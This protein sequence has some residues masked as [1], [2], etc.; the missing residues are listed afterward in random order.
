VTLVRGAGFGL[1]T[2]MGSALIAGYAVPGARGSSLGAYGVA[3]S[4]WATFAPALGLAAFRGWPPL[5]A[6]AMGGLPPLLGLIAL[7]PRMPPAPDYATHPG[8]REGTAVSAT[9]VPPVTVFVAVAATLAAAFTFVPLLRVGSTTLLL[10]LFGTSFT[11][12]RLLAGYLL[13]RGRSATR[14]VLWLLVGVVIG[15]ALLGTLDT[16]VVAV[17]AAASGLGIGCV[18]TATL[19]M[20]LDRV[21][22]SG[23]AR[24]SVIWNMAFDVGQA[25][26]AV[27]FGAIAALLDPSGVFLAGAALVA[28]VAVPA[29]AFDWRR[30]RVTAPAPA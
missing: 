30:M 10:V 20:T 5:T 28:L 16:A 17:G 21:G 9:L 24:A 1:L 27:L 4:I 19:V 23:V 3:S 13:D 2:V 11:A 7:I 8:S 25:V 29:A 26:G 18:C 14:L 6:F 15:L 12:G 22:K